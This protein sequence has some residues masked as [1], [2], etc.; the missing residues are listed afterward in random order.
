M[1]LITLPKWICL[2]GPEVPI[3]HFGNVLLAELRELVTEAGD[4]PKSSLKVCFGLSFIF[5]LFFLFSAYHLTD[6]ILINVHFAVEQE[7]EL[8]KLILTFSQAGFLLSKN[9]VCSLA[10]QYAHEKKIKGF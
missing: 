10:Y 7:K 8:V 4:T 5:N 6:S 9:K 1:D 3:Q 2:T